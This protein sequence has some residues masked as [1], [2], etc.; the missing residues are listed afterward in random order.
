MEGI[1]MKTEE[2][3]INVNHVCDVYFKRSGN[4]FYKKSDWSGRDIDY[5]SKLIKI[6]QEP[7]VI[8]GSY[9]KLENVIEKK[10]RLIYKFREIPA[11]DSEAR[12][13]NLSVKYIYYKII[14]KLRLEN[15]LEK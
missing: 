3:K 7:L 5:I 8:G 1:N 9:D 15:N 12:R 2:L 11:R 14:P 13:E 6:I 4:W 10:G